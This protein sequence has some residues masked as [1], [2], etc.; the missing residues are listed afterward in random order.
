[1]SRN[2]VLPLGFL[3][4]SL[5]YEELAT[6]HKQT[7]NKLWFLDMVEISIPGCDIFS[8]RLLE[9]LNWVFLLFAEQREHLFFLDKRSLQRENRFNLHSKSAWVVCSVRY[10][11]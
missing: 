5:K 10:Y 1:M 11:T 9:G 3:F 2:Q 7:R 6:A 8:A 4:P